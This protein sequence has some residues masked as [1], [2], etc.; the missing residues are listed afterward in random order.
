[1]RREPADGFA[2]SDL[3]SSDEVLR[4]PGRAWAR[5]SWGTTHRTGARG[6][7]RSH[8]LRVATATATIVVVE[9]GHRKR[10]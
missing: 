9:I 5:G 8:R 7:C 2:H 1:M 10:S 3:S 6:N 4:A